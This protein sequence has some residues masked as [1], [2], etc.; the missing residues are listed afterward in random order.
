MFEMMLLLFLA[1]MLFFLL[2]L[3]WEINNAPLIEDEN[4]Y[5][6]PPKED[7]K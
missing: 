1:F 3:N 4:D 7:L 6:K 5:A 2:W